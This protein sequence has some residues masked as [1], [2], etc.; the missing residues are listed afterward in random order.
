[1]VW[2]T[3]SRVSLAKRFCI[4][5]TFFMAQSLCALSGAFFGIGAEVNA[6]TREGAALA[7]GVSLGVELN[8]YFSLGLNTSF[9]SNL[10]TI[11]ALEP[12]ALFRYYPPLNQPSLFVQ[13]ELGTAVFFENGKVFPAFL[14]A[15]GAGWHF[16]LDRWYIEPILRFGYPFIWGLG[17]SVGIRFDAITFGIL[18]R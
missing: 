4:I 6:N 5:F 13:G 12:S 1:M 17:L 15:I 18:N 9:S 3:V 7:G 10:D 14:G 11:H 16:K 8:R 2:Y